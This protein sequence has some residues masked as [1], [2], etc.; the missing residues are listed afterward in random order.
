MKNKK[1]KLQYPLR[2]QRQT[3]VIGFDQV[4]L[5]ALGFSARK[6]LRVRLSQR[7]PSLGRFASISALVLS[8]IIFPDRS[9]RV[10]RFF[11]AL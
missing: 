7:K 6:I 10:S 4:A 3:R 1:K 2:I 5:R 9:A 11:E 8:A